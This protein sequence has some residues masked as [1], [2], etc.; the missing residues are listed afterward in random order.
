MN[1]AT[2]IIR[3]AADVFVVCLLVALLFYNYKSARQTSSVTSELLSTTTN[4]FLKSD[5]STLE[6]TELPGTTVVSMV[7]KYQ[8][9]LPVKVVTL[10]GGNR[11]YTGSNIIMNTDVASPNY[12]KAES[13]FVCTHEENMNKVITQ[14]NFVEQG[15]VAGAS[16]ITNIDDA[17]QLFVDSM[18]GLQGVNESQTWTELT[19]R[20]R[21]ELS[22]NSKTQLSSAL[23][24][25][26][27]DTDTWS[28][29]AAA[30]TERILTL[31]SQ[32]NAGNTGHDSQTTV[33]N[34][35]ADCVLNFMPLYAVVTDTEN[36]DKYF[37][38]DSTWYANGEFMSVPIFSISEDADG[39]CVF[40]NRTDKSL[41][42]TIFK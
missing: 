23:G 25:A 5:L 42:I 40:K 3:T 11:T 19:D 36:N 37:F 28:E 4:D 20:L 33:C 17:K 18:N 13:S 27:L 22:L 21:I 14:I 8:N 10:A 29:L 32:V 41:N 39:Y 15:V 35:Y 30:A 34:S 38:Y 24:G 31:E 26:Y 6:G 12:V 7:K 2:T 9:K 1:N 16:D